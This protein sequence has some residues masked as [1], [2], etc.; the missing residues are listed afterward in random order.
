MGEAQPHAILVEEVFGNGA[1]HSLA[2]VQLQW[3]GLHLG[4]PSG[5]V[6]DAV[7]D[8]NKN[9]VIRNTQNKIRYN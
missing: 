4:R 5:H 7:L 9:V 3:E 8:E 2:I 1:L 6:A